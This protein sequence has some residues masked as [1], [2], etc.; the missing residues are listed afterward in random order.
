VLGQRVEKGSVVAVRF[1]SEEKLFGIGESLA[2]TVEQISGIIWCLFIF[3]NTVVEEIGEF[4]EVNGFLT[5]AVN[6]VG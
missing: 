1:E 6:S 2:F 5:P 3:G 4:G